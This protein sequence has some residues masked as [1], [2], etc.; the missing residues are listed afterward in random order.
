MKKNALITGG[1]SGIG[2]ATAKLL[3]EKG[4]AVTIC[5]RNKER[6]DK[7]SSEL[8]VTGIVAD[9]ANL[10]DI[11]SLSNKFIE[12]GLD[13][14][15]NN[16][17]VAKFIPIEANTEEDFDEFFKTNIRGPLALIQALLPALKI[18]KGSITTVS[19]A[20]TNNGLPNA[21]IYAAT[22]GAVDAFTKSLALELAPQNVRINA[23][24]PGAI[25]TPIITK[26]GLSEEQIIAIKEHQ[27]TLIPMHRFGRPEEVAQVILAQLEST[28][29]TGS[30]WS[31]DGGVDAY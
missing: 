5:G 6:V 19:S 3:R 8:N 18:K 13:V 25:D 26:L 9:M 12:T 4:Y 11:T 30:I 2:F 16:A 22:K 20:V 24:S 17:A 29:V 10:D 31:V 28:Y 7:A 15:V 1:N 14:L 21:S 23:V 27:E